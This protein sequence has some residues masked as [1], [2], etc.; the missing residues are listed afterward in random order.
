[1]KIM[2]DNLLDELVHGEVVVAAQRRYGSIAE[3]VIDLAYGTESEWVVLD[4]K[5]DGVV[6]TDGA[7]AEQLRLYVRRCSER[8]ASRLAGYCLKFGRL[9]GDLPYG[10]ILHR[11]DPK[12]PPSVPARSYRDI[13]RHQP[14]LKLASTD[15]SPL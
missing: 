1:M 12:A 5:T 13:Y 9:A 3:G 15:I 2:T 4:F 10:P 6:S 11:R 7:Y 8:P 14:S